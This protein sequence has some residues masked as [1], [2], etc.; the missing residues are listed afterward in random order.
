MKIHAADAARL[1]SQIR[2]NP[3]SVSPRGQGRTT[4]ETEA[5]IAQRIIQALVST[6]LLEFPLELEPN[7]RPDL[8][9]QMPSGAVGIEI[10]EIVPPVY[11]QAVA[12]RNQYYKGAIVDRSLFGWG[13]SFT[14]KQIHDHFSNQPQF[15]TGNGWS[16]DQVEQEWARATESAVVRKLERLNAPGFNV[17]PRNWLAAYASSPGP[18]LDHEHAAGLVSLQPPAAGPH[19]FE[20]VFVLSGERLVIFGGRTPRVELVPR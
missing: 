15:L 16:G 13:A 2:A 10:T 14:P 4:L 19:C 11:A 3:A 20:K 12:I 17:L 6:T 7:D 9:L 5:W 18:A 1:V 8:I